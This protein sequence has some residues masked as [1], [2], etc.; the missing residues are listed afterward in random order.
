MFELA[1]Y[2]QVQQRIF[3]EV[4]QVTTSNSTL[5]FDDYPQLKYTVQV[6]QE[7]LRMHTP[8]VASFKRTKEPIELTH[9]IK[10]T[11]ETLI[12]IMLY[13]V[14]MDPEYWD[15]PEVFNP[16]RFASKLKHPY[17]FVPF[18]SGSRSCIGDKFSY[19]EASM[20]I[21]CIVQHYVVDYQPGFDPATV[22]EDEFLIVRPANS[23]IRLQKR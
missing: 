4:S 2:P 3:E 15:A 19:I 11:A 14:H 20:I 22:G 17:C 21:A 9:G 7:V 12:M 16:D 23:Q 5:T 1:R 6:L 10:L 13:E 18:S 8:V